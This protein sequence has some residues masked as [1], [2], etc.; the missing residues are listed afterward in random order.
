MDSLKT[1]QANFSK[2]WMCREPRKQ[3]TC[4]GSHRRVHAG[5]KMEHSRKTEKHRFRNK[6]VN[7]YTH[8]IQDILYENIEKFNIYA[9]EICLKSPCWETFYLGF[10]TKKKTCFGSFRDALGKFRFLPNL[11]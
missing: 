8:I 2:N 4:R 1:C 7:M 11:W 6:D 3:L 5:V 9:I 10:N